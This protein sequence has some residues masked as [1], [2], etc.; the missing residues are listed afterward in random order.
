MNQKSGE[1]QFP[2]ARA[3]LTM[4][5]RA[6]DNVDF[7]TWHRENVSEALGLKTVTVHQFIDLW[8]ELVRTSKLTR[9]Q[10]RSLSH[11]FHKYAAALFSYNSPYYY[12]QLMSVYNTLPYNDMYFD[13]SPEQPTAV[14]HD[15]SVTL[16]IVLPDEHTWSDD[17]EITELRPLPAEETPIV[18]LPD[19]DVDG[20]TFTQLKAFAQENG[21]DAT[22][23]TRKN[24][25]KQAV[26]DYLK[27]H[28]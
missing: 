16:P 1:H 15:E 20:A 19:F 25:L 28:S 3:V 26:A 23:I 7:E 18:L 2:V 9:E 4:L 24:D 5:T 22:G 6:N 21:I 27:T 14:A 8:F 17:V 10:R 12:V 13:A 11:I